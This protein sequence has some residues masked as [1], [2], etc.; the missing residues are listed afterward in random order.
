MGLTGI[1]SSVKSASHAG[2]SNVTAFKKIN[3]N[4]KWRRFLRYGLQ[5][6]P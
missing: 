1:D 3:T 4:H 6:L 2:W 5:I